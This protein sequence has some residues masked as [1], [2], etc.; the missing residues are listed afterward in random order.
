M[1]SLLL[2]RVLKTGCVG[3]DVEG[4]TRAMIRYLNS[5]SEWTAFVAALPIVRRTWGAGK[6]RLAKRCAAK[7]GLP[8]YGVMGPA[9][10]RA[11]RTAGAFDLKANRLL[12][13][14]ADS[15]KP[16]LVEPRQGFASLDR[17]LW[18]AYSI[19]RRLGLTDL[20]TH[21]SASRLPG[22]GMSDHAVYP[23]MAFDLG[24]SPQTGWDNLQAR[25]VALTLAGRPEIEYVILGSR[26]W[27]S[28]GWGSYTA[29]GHFNHIHVSGRR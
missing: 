28:R 27:T 29:G 16:K 10:E 22:G 13:E 1:P 21:N 15:I 26:I 5:G 4:T 9:L 24:F 2:T 25:S 14:Y 3:K 8:Q 19:G 6:T 20:G 18:E 17:S 11:I 7:A 23:A 12:D